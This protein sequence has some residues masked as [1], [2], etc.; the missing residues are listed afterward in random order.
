MVV[1]AEAIL[2][3]LRKVAVEAGPLFLRDR[4]WHEKLVG[5]DHSEILLLQQTMDICVCSY[6]FSEGKVKYNSRN[7][8]LHI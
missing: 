2:K 7:V 3:D 8:L 5:V 4:M 1:V 6:V